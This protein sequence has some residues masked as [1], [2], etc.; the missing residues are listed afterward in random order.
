IETNR[1]DEIGGVADSVNELAQ[2]LERLKELRRQVT[3][4]VAHELRTPLHNLLGLI[5]G[6]RDGVIPA[7][8]ERLQQAH[9]E[10]GRLIALVEDLRG[11]ADAQLARDRMAHEP[12]NIETVV[13]DVV[14]GFDASMER[15]RLRCE[16]SAPDGECIVDGDAVRLGQVVAN[17]V[18]NAI[19]YARP[20]T[21]VRVIL[22]KRRGSVRVAVRD[23]GETIDAGSLPHI[24]ERFFRADRSRS[25]ST[26][27]SGLGLAIVASVVRAHGG[28]VEAR[29]RPGGGAVFR[30]VLPALVP[31]SGVGSGQE[32]GS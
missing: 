32:D 1:R 21:V 25:R 19:R 16:I 13:R 9:A 4:D 20:D 17:I 27:G 14:L 24:F 8:R 5:E 30:V 26:G 12:L 6:M 3:N 29:P 28:R 7:S 10:L 22:T 31:I 23:T 15:H 2:S 18:D 11:L